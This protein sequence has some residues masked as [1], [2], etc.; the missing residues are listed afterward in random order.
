MPQCVLKRLTKEA[1]A[2]E[3]KGRSPEK[4]EQS[5]SDKQDKP[6]FRPEGKLPTR[7][8]EES[9]E[10][11]FKPVKHP[12]HSAKMFHSEK[13]GQTFAAFMLSFFLSKTYEFWQRV[14][15][16]SRQAQGRCNDIAMLA[17]INGAR[18]MEENGDYTPEALATLRLLLV[19]WYGFGT[20]VA[21]TSLFLLVNRAVRR[22]SHLGMVNGVV[23]VGASCGLVVGPIVATKTFAWS[24]LGGAGALRHCTAF[25]VFSAVALFELIVTLFLSNNG[26]TYEY[27]L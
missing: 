23:S 17:V 25:L 12:D 21:Q 7:V 27:K 5:I 1:A 2:L 14:Y 19:G 20:S 24:L 6:S 4:D 18:E 11:D 9:E 8:H 13:T 26:S 22:L 16:I 10:A 3:A 15:S